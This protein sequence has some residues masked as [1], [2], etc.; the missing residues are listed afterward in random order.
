MQVGTG[1]RVEM[2]YYTL[3]NNDRRHRLTGSS[4]FSPSLSLVSVRRSDG[5]VRFGSVPA[6]LRTCFTTVPPSPAY[7]GDA[8]TDTGQQAVCV[9]I[10]IISGITWQ[11]WMYASTGSAGVG[12]GEEWKRRVRV[13]SSW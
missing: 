6:C 13:G 1:E 7:I 10:H 5:K 11:G 3:Y 8:T 4:R 2:P 12:E 9:L